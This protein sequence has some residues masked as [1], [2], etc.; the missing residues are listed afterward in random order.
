MLDWPAAKGLPSR[1]GPYRSK[2]GTLSSQMVGE[3]SAAWLLASRLFQSSLR[4]SEEKQSSTV[5]Q[6]TG[7]QHIVAPA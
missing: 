1:P 7:W 6:K 2:P 4:F 3:V 5:T